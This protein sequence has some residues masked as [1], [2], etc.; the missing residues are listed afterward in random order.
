M[1]FRRR[2]RPFLFSPVAVTLVAVVGRWMSFTC[3]VGAWCCLAALRADGGGWGRV[4]CLNSTTAT[5][6]AL[7]GDWRECVRVSAGA[8][9]TVHLE[10]PHLSDKAVLGHRQPLDDRK[11]AGASFCLSGVRASEKILIEFLGVSKMSAMQL[12]GCHI[13]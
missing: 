12:G 3:R 4:T 13:I 9:A 8:A 11:A 6:V 1:A 2:S 10:Q 5:K 7:A